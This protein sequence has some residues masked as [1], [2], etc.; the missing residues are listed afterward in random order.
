ML[1]R[2]I[3][4]KFNGYIN[5]DLKFENKVT[6]I[7]G[8]DGYGKK[9]VLNIIYNLLKGHSITTAEYVKLEF[10]DGFTIVSNHGKLKTS[11]DD[12]TKL[13]FLYNTKKSLNNIIVN[14]VTLEQLKKSTSS[15]M[16]ILF[17]ISGLCGIEITNT[18]KVFYQ[19]SDKI[20]EVSVIYIS[21][22]QIISLDERKFSVNLFDS[23]VK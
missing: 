14:L 3:I 8:P 19:I 9:E 12:V 2:V 18:K 15:E 13:T 23:V 21:D 11:S 4:K 7:T 16:I 1:K 22:E 6:S 5:Y 20:P 17:D 10:S